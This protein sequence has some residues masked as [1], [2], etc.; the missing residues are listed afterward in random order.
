MTTRTVELAC[1]DVGLPGGR[2]L[3]VGLH[4]E[5]DGTAELVLAA[6]F[7][8]RDGWARLLAE[9]VNLPAEALPELVRALEA[10]RHA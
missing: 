1:I 8:E 4:K 10:L 7:P 5:P 3:R 6:G 2:T 9:A